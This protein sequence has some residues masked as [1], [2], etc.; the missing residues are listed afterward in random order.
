[1][2]F[3]AAMPIATRVNVVRASPV[4]RSSDPPFIAGWGY[5]NADMVLGAMPR[6]GRPRSVWRRWQPEQEA[7]LA[8]R[9]CLLQARKQLARV[10]R[11]TEA[12][13]GTPPAPMV[14]A[15]HWRP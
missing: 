1:M 8:N 6:H 15:G 9:S 3:G 10:F 7:G 5:Q 4:P 13:M 12:R 2:I 14:A 11:A